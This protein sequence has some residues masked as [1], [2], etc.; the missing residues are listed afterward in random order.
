LQKFHSDVE[1][2]SLNVTLSRMKKR[3]LLHR[4]DLKAGGTEG[5]FSCRKCS[6][7]ARLS[8][9][10]R[11]AAGALLISC[12]ECRGFI[13]A[14]A[15]ADQTVTFSAARLNRVLMDAAVDPFFRREVRNVI[16]AFEKGN[17]V[18]LTKSFRVGF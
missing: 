4:Q 10:Y 5:I 9:V 18:R 3:K 1:E 2:N 14:L 7:D 17:S 11:K 12:R 6:S 8:F 13:V 16:A 15:I